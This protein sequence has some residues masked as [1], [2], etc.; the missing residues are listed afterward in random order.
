MTTIARR[1][2]RPSPIKLVLLETRYQQLL[3][4]RNR[5]GAVFTIVFSSLFLVLLSASNTGHIS[6]L[7]HIKYAQYY[8]PGFMAYGVMSA[9]FNNLAI[10][11]VIRRENGLLK[12]LRLSP[13][14]GWALIAAIVVNAMLVSFV[15]AILLLLIGIL[16]FGV[17]LTAGAIVPI[18]IAIVVGAGAFSALGLAVSTVVPN[19]DSAGPAISIVF[20]LLL[21]LS[22]LW[23][24]L[25]SG[26]TLAK[27]SNY[28]PVRRLILV[29]TQPFIGHGTSPWD[30]HDLLVIAIWGIVGSYIAA[31]R[32]KWSRWKDDHPGK[33]TA[34]H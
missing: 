16:G 25:T 22:G 5:F 32:F 7:H 24:P 21:F 30:W 6:S 20:F 18:I 29:T 13:L 17:T 14:P 2:T 1:P 28:F 33:A 31:R 12:R 34:G 3:F 10:S 27:I 11:T 26:S 8:T 9:C 23:F 15:G 4:W 19:E